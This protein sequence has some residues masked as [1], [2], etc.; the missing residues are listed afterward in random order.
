MAKPILPNEL[1]EAVR[2][3]VVRPRAYPKGGRPPVNDRAALTG[4]L[5]V[6]TH[7]IRWEDLPLELG[8]GSGMTCWRRWREWLRLGIWDDVQA[9]V[10]AYHPEPHRID[11]SRL[12]AHAQPVQRCRRRRAAASPE[13]LASEHQFAGLSCGMPLQA[14]VAS[15]P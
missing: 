13:P 10:D 8:C 5:F 3:L 12:N 14:S 11:W 7:R 4:I 1:W 9:V 15:A 6:L 2:P